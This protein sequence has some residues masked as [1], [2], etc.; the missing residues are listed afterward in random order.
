MGYH[1]LASRSTM[2][3][4]YTGCST[5]LRVLAQL[6]S[7]RGQG[8]SRDNGAPS[9]WSPEE[10]S[11]A[12]GAFSCCGCSFP[13]AVVAFAGP[14]WLYF[15]TVRTVDAALGQCVTALA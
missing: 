7:S 5:R 14:S 1:A 13:A 9:A 3:T 15:A 10:A 11:P 6:A 4:K 8:V 2:L 12:P